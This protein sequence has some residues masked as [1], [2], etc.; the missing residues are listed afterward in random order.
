MSQQVLESIQS[1]NGL[2]TTINREFDVDTLKNDLIVYINELKKD[3]ENVRRL[4][5]K[6]EEERKI[7]PDNAKVE[8]LKSLYE[9][10]NKAL[11]SST[12]ELEKYKATLQ[13]LKTVGDV[14]M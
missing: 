11:A 7:A 14:K 2:I 1:L 12:S 9:E 5:Q 8:G 6:I 4:T 13:F 10:A 3:K